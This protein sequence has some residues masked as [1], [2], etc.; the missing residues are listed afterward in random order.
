MPS[1]AVNFTVNPVYAVT[2][3]LNYGANV[4]HETKTVIY[5]A[6]HIDALPTPPIRAPFTFEG[7]NTLADGSGT[8]FTATT[9]V[10]GDT[11]VY[12][13]WGFSVAN[14]A[15]WDAV[16]SAITGEGNDKAYNI[17]VTGDF[18][19]P[20]TTDATFGAVTGITVNI[21]GTGKIT[22]SS[23]STTGRCLWIG[24]GQ[25]VNL[26]DVQLE[27][28]SAHT[29]ALLSIA[30]GTFNM[31]SGKISGNGGTGVHVVDGTFNMSGGEI[32]GNEPTTAGGTVLVLGNFNM[33]GGIIKN[34][35]NTSGGRGVA[36]V[37]NTSPATFDMSGTAKIIDNG[38][39]SVSATL[40]SSN[41]LYFGG[42]VYVQAI[43]ANATFNMSGNAEISGNYMANGGGVGIDA[44]TSGFTAAFYMTGGTIKGNTANGTAKIADG[45]ANRPYGGGVIVNGYLGTAT[46]SMTG[47]TITGNTVNNPTWGG[48]GGGV[49]LVSMNSS[50][51]PQY[52]GNTATFDLKSLDMVHG[53]TAGSGSGVNQIYVNPGTFLINGSAVDPRNDSDY[54]W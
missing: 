25:T 40:T 49:A 34:N 22:I 28:H 39:S 16:V 54:Y 12:A 4:T 32:S 8:A 43:G 53:N 13:Q 50:A 21:R 2:F 27:G 51:M 3:K 31:E 10:T 18:D 9:T 42:G 6:T 33:T 29:A 19:I 52:T 38:N 7:W 44:K 24:A 45:T 26:K 46:F 23:S 17:V 11:T 14:A 20:G 47:G 30:G 41:T 37:G 36:V 48:R 15:D 5:P 1:N 35:G